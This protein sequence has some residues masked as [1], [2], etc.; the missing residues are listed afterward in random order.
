V[1]F[2]TRREAEGGQLAWGKTGKLGVP[3]RDTGIRP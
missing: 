3:L 1:A 2:P